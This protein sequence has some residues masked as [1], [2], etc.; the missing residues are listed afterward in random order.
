MPK[1]NAHI[2]SQKN[3][4]NCMRLAETLL[5]STIGLK[6]WQD[7][8]NDRISKKTGKSRVCHLKSPQS[9]ILNLT[10]NNV[11]D[12]FPIHCF[13]CFDSVKIS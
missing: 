2:V 1:M 11:L 13:Y 8:V 5:Y 6:L 3:M 4:V 7:L 9:V 12:V 10:F